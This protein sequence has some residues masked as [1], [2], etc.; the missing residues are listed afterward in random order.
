[1]IYAGSRA[2]CPRNIDGLQNICY[3]VSGLVF[4]NCGYGL[5]FPGESDVFYEIGG[6]LCGIGFF[7]KCFN[8]EVLFKGN[9]LSCFNVLWT[10]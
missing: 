5:D 3:C 10:E 4:R 2:K 7:V 6:V 9:R 8:R 1:M